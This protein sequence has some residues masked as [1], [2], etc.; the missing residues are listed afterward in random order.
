MI[1]GFLQ[2]LQRTLGAKDVGWHAAERSQDGTQ[3]RMAPH[4][5]AEAIRIEL[6]RLV[7]VDGWSISVVPAGENLLNAD[8]RIG[9]THRAVVVSALPVVGFAPEGEALLESVG[10]T[11]TNAAWSS[12]LQAFGVTV[13]L[14]AEEDGWVDVDPDTGIALY[15]PVAQ[16]APISQSVPAGLS[17]SLD[18]EVSSN[19]VIGDPAPAPSRD[20]AKPETRKPEGHIMI[21]RIV[22]RLRQDGH[23]ADVARL[24]TRYGGYGGDAE[25][26]RSLYAELRSLLREKSGTGEK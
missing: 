15:P 13:P 19:A 24:V 17:D 14:V 26:S 25:Q 8:L 11:L 16:N 9:D 21:D 1:S 7:G 5:M 10:E 23:G 18:A 12:A 6:D 2:D 20:E 22:E 3:L 4:I